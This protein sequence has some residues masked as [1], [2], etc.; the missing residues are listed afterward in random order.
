MVVCLFSFTDL[1]PSVFP[2][3]I[4]MPSVEEFSISDEG[5][6]SASIFKTYLQN[7]IFGYPQYPAP[8]MLTTIHQ[9]YEN[10]QF[11]AQ[12]RPITMLKSSH[13]KT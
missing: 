10:M 8:L 3:S 11:V 6:V 5:I 9:F 2:E 12:K 4:D 13:K 1:L 7:Q